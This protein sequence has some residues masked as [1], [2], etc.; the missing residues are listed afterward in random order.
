MPLNTSL[1]S[2][3]PSPEIQQLVMMIW[4]TIVPV[5]MEVLPTILSMDLGH[6]NFYWHLW[7]ALMVGRIMDSS[8]MIV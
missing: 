8:V 2:S 3:S 7:Y 6:I 4:L 5:A 1:A